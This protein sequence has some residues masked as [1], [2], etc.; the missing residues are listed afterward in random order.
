MGVGD[1]SRDLK[2]EVM[3]EREDVLLK[4]FG[5]EVLGLDLTFEW[6]SLARHKADDEAAWVER[7]ALFNGRTEGAAPESRVLQAHGA[8]V[9]RY[10]YMPAEFLSPTGRPVHDLEQRI[11]R[12]V[13]Q[14]KG[15]KFA[16]VQPV[17]R[18]ALGALP[19]ALAT[20]TKSGAGQ[21]DTMV[22]CDPARRFRLKPAARDRVGGVRGAEV[23][24]L[25]CAHCGAVHASDVL[26]ACHP[27]AGATR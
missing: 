20:A 14:V 17:S 27:D 1:I 10:S 8:I 9:Q 4:R 18:E 12:L 7:Y 15:E 2:S 3:K 21:C 6:D 25:A 26:H 13:T 24:A 23:F 19:S 5:S 22:A 16:T 11:L